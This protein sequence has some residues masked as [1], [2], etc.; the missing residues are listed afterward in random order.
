MFQNRNNKKGSTMARIYPICSSSMGNSTFIGT[1]GH[2]IL[3]DAG[4]SFRA[5]TNALDL[6]DTKTENIEAIF[7]THEHIDHIKA[8]EQI[9]KHTKIP[10][11]A[12]ELSAAQM[13]SEGRI[14]RE[15]EIFDAREGYK[16]AAFEVSCFKTSHDSS[17][18]VGYKI[19]YNKELFGV[20]TDTGF[21][22]EETK[23]ALMGCTT[24]LIESNYDEN[25]LRK[26]PNYSALLKRRIMGEGGHLSNDACAEFCETLVRGG[27]RHLI[28]GHLSQEN[29]TP[30]TAKNRV[31]SHLEQ[32]G[33]LEE[34]DFTLTAAPVM[35]SGEY[36]AV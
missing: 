29:N 26:N 12:P 15:A 13:K 35:T 23:K 34:K 7:I 2:G 9:I 31:K 16:S 5:L 11:F 25:M 24:V 4:C 14:P 10:I 1:R 8:L 6:I 19:V 30:A 32:R 17:D 21:V 33:L 36:I 20:C 27:T 28:L 18:S 3:V 22:T